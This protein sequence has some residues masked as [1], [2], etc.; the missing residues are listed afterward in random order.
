[1]KAS[2]KSKYLGGVVLCVLLA[3]VSSLLSGCDADSMPVNP[4]SG[5]I[6]ITEAIL[7]DFPLFA[8]N[9]VSTE[10]IDPE[11]VDN[12]EVTYGEVTITVPHYVSSLS[13]MSVAITSRELNL[14]KFSISPGNSDLLSFEGGTVHT[15]TISTVS[16]NEPI[17][18]YNVQ[19]VKEPAPVR[20]TL[21]IT[22]FTFEQ[23]K[24]PSL[25]ADVTIS[26]TVEDGG[27]DIIYLFVPLGTDFTD[28]VPTIEYDG[29]KLLYSQDN[30]S[31]YTK[32]PDV[33]TSI[34]FKYPK[35]FAL[36]VEDRDGNRVR[37]TSVIVDVINPVR[38][39]QVDVT[40]PDAPRGSNHYFTG[41]TKWINQ[42]NHKIN[43]QKATT[44]ENQS[45]V[46]TPT[47]NV[48]RA[49]RMLP[50]G[51][52]EPGE[53]AAVHVDVRA[54]SLPKGTYKTTAVFYTRIYHDYN[55]NDLFE[56]VKVN[57]TANIV[58]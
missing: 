11:I 15:F 14:S 45:P 57:I 50:S 16:D 1:M 43:F 47:Y 26:R 9:D 5:E 28:L 56:P 18:H 48:I 6:D 55:S 58:D 39:E 33:D 44:Y 37:S 27:R 38:I 42:G 2:K 22:G 29:T 23:S 17:L 54:G 51:G 12:K 13:A 52:L 19:V 10:I 46:I 8:I 32:F 31:G 49:N 20:E 21:K 4:T 40:T 24:N 25:P 7:P 36:N 53:S 35:Y 34:D 3:I 41:V 30:S